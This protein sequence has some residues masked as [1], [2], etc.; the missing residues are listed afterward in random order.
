MK[1]KVCVFVCLFLMD[2]RTAAGMLMILFLFSLYESWRGHSQLWFLIVGF[3]NYT[4]SINYFTKN[5]DKNYKRNY[6]L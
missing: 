5:K 3:F 1:F 2:S 4:I 6:E